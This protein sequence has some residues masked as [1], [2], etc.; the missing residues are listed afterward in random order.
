MNKQ[1]I[2]LEKIARKIRQTIVKMYYR[3]GWG[4]LAPAL[5]CTDILVSI[6]FGLA[7]D[8][9]SFFVEGNDSF[10]LSKGHACAALYAVYSELGIIDRD[11]LNTFYQDNSRLIGLASPT[12]PRIE[13][14]TGSL[15]H[16]ICFAT[17]K[18]LIAKRDNTGARTY[19][20]LGD[21]ESQEGSVWE[22]AEFAGAEKLDNLIVF[23][24]RNRLQASDW[25]DNILCIDPVKSRWESFGWEVFET[26]G[27]DYK[28]IT[29][30]LN[31]A[32]N[33]SKRPSLVIANTVKGK[34]VSIAENRPDWHSRA[35]KG[36]EWDAV[37]AEI[38]IEQVDLEFI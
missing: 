3:A 25:I 33:N 26:D 24:D 23:L 34:G 10:V 7:P 30:V 22:A 5:S 13:I 29:D 8:G 19:V 37:C 38:G 16:G 14:P 27:H 35:P 15:G 12:I 20:L 4:H 32:K 6:F 2:E 36:H 9:R 18:A 28:K 31:L 11:E 1:F 21:G 17:G